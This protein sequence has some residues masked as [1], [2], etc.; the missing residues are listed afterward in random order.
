VFALEVEYLL[1]RSFAASFRDRS[2]AEWPPHPARLFSALA[3][4]YFENGSVDRERRALEWLESQPAPLIHAGEASAGVRTEAFVP[5]NYVKKGDYLPAVRNKQPRWFPAQSPSDP[6]VHF[7]WPR[8]EPD[9]ETSTGLDELASRTAYLGRSC[10]VVRVRVAPDAPSPN[11][12]P[13]AEGGEILRVPNAGRLKELEQLFATDQ[14]PTPGAQV[15]YRNIGVRPIVTLETAFD[16][17]AIFRKVSG[18]DLPIEATV[19][20]TAAVRIALLAN[21]GRDGTLTPLLHGHDGTPHCA[22]AALPFV[23]GKHADGHLMGFAVILPRQ[24][25]PAGRRAVLSACGDLS[26]NGL[27]IPEIGDWPIEPEESTTLANT[28]RASTWIRP[29]RTWRS[30][31]PILLDQFPKRNR[32]STE[33]IL[34]LACERVGLPAPMSI[35]HQPYSDLRGVPPVPAFR[36]RR[37]FDERPRWSVHATLTFHDMVRGPLLLGAG[38]FFGLGLM[39]PESTE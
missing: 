8:S 33:E 31:T 37:K 3:A 18:P 1:R 15:R 28:L 22:I 30:V 19:T 13:S 29:A 11:Y 21:A 6:V 12:E 20:L 39:R 24:S 5:A 34:A 10:S 4:A 7:I 23:G 14:R 35:H 17:M 32:R 26:R 36:L 25:D 2:D 16:Q 9:I 27:H 38:R